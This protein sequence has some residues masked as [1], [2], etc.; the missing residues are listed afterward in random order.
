MAAYCYTSE[1]TVCVDI[2]KLNSRHKNSGYAYKEC[3][4]IENLLRIK[5]ISRTNPN[6]DIT[7]V[8][9]I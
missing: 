6:M 7:I 8:L 2:I 4:K 5:Y 1:Y 3:L 9:I